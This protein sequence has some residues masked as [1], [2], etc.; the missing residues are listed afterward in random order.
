MIALLIRKISIYS[1][2][3]AIIPKIFLAYQAW[4][5][6]GIILNTISMA[7]FVFFWRAVYTQTSSIGGMDVQQTLTY[8]L[9]AQ[10][11]APVLDVFVMWEFGYNLR[12]GG[13]AITLLRPVDTQASYYVQGLAQMLTLILLQV[14]MLLVAI[15]LFGL[16]LPFDPAVWAA[17]LVSLLLGRTVLFFLDW[18]LA[19]VTFYTTEVWGLGVL[20]LG[21]SMFMNGSLIPL[22]MMPDRLQ[23]VVQALP[24][25]QTLYVPLALLT[26]ISPLSEAP[27]LWLTQIA[28]IIGLAVASRLIFSLAVRKVTVQ[29]G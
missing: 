24:F 22:V 29:G 14:P 23:A 16:R 17:F 4:F 18:I 20:V 13:I 9:L 3:A 28:W 2:F 11:F 8:I 10:V 21:F 12:E 19:S 7:I 15:L 6:V 27:R 5:W 25:A 26:G 1:A